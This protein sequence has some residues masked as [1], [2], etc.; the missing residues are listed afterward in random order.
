M[1]ANVIWQS[2]YHLAL[3]RLHSSSL[4]STTGSITVLPQTP[5]FMDFK[6]G[7]EVLLLCLA[8][9]ASLSALQSTSTQKTIWLITLYYLSSIDTPSH[10]AFLLLY[11]LSCTNLELSDSSIVFRRAP[12]ANSRSKFVWWLTLLMPCRSSP[13]HAATCWWCWSLH[14]AW[15]ALPYQ[16]PL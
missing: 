14:P 4:I 8:V 9:L 10:G 5:G 3:H 2:S 15:T 6:K 11:I 16:A 13:W 7:Y 12:T 1:L